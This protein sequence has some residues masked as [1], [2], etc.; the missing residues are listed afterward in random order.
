MALI[1]SQIF[2]TLLH[3]C[4]QQHNSRICYRI[5]G[6]FGEL[7]FLSIW[8]KKVWRINRSANR[9][10]IVR[11]NLDGFNLANHGRFTKF[12][13]LRPPHHQTFLLYGIELQKKLTCKCNYICDYTQNTMN[14]TIFT[15]NMINYNT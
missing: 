1:L 10:L 8:R 12:A 15:H 7:T 14:I 3:S 2:H 6:K 13:N 5:A 11:T 4:S 9:L